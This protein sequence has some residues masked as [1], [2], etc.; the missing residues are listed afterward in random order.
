MKPSQLKQQTDLKP[1]PGSA[2][3]SDY[4]KSGNQSSNVDSGRGSAAYSSGR[5]GGMNG[6][7]T[8]G[9]GGLANHDTSPENSDS[10]IR[11]LKDTDSEWVDIVDAE[12]RNILEP[13][14]QSL[15]LRPESTISGSVSSMS[16]PVPNEPNDHQQRYKPN[17]MHPQG[18]MK[19]KHE[20]G[21]DSYNRPPRSSG[22]IG[23]SRAG[24]PGSTAMQ[25]QMRNGG[26]VSS[27]KQEQTMLK[28]HRK[29]NSCLPLNKYIN[30]SSSF[31]SL[32]WTT[33]SPRLLRDHWT[34]SRCWALLGVLVIL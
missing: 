13:G 6:G 3:S 7:I 5:K 4:D 25:K 19:D 14:M 1:Q 15:T 17:Q 12:L 27:K 22:P 11:V 16:P 21:T 29:W 26:G 24:F 8:G 2:A 30:H 34:W 28:R 31:Q 23:P 32:V 33:T 10:P 9:V 20:Y 18:G